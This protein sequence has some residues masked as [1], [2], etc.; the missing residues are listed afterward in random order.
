[1]SNER[2][3]QYATKYIYLTCLSPRQIEHTTLNRCSNQYQLSIYLINGIISVTVSHKFTS[4]ATHHSKTDVF[5]A[6][7][8]VF[9]LKFVKINMLFMQRF[10][11]EKFK[12]KR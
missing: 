4:L 5:L 9:S 8:F 3:Q 11:R 6:N 10:C 2:Y 12:K 1:L 7:C